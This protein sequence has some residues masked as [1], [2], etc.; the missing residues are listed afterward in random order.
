MLH[1]KQELHETRALQRKGRRV[2]IRDTALG[3]LPQGDP[4]VGRG[5]RPQEG[6]GREAAKGEQGDRPEALEETPEDVLGRG[7]RKKDFGERDRRVDQRD[8][9][10][11][12][13]VKRDLIRL[14]NEQ[15]IPITKI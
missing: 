2:L 11:S 4:L 8:S 3:D 12:S 9:L 6:E 1:E 7:P 15:L 5:R 14:L 10:C 13:T